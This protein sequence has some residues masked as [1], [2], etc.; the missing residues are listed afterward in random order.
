MYQV[1]SSL[2]VSAASIHMEQNAARWWQVQKLKQGARVWTEFVTAVEGKFGADAYAKALR[3]LRNLKQVDTLDS[4]VHEFEQARYQAA[5][6]NTR[7]DELFFVTQF[8]HGLKLEIQH[9][10]QMHQPTTVDKAA[11]LA[12]LQQEMLEKG[13]HKVARQGYATKQNLAGNKVDGRGQ[14]M[15][16]ELF[17][18]RQV[19]EFRK[20]NGLCYACGEKFEPGHLAKCVRRK[21]VQLN[22]VVTE[23]E[24]MELTDDVLQKLAQE[25]EREDHCCRL[26]FQA[27][28]GTDNEQSMRIRSVVG[29]HTMLM[30]V[31]S[32]SSSNFISQHMVHM[33]GLKVEH[34]QPVKV[35]VASG[36]ALD[37]N[38]MVKNLEWWSHGHFY[39][40]DMRVLP[41]GVFDAIL[42]YEWLMEHSP[43]ECDWIDKVLQFKDA[44]Q[45]VKLYGDGAGNNSSIQ[46]VSVLQVQKWL[47][48]HEVWVM[49]LLE[50][51]KEDNST[52]QHEDIQALLMEFADLFSIPT[53]LP[54]VREFDHH[55]PLLPGAVPVNSK[56]YRYS[57]FHK[58][59]IERQVAALLKAG[60]ITPSASPFASPVLL[61]KKKDGSWRFCVD[62][63]KLNDL[64]IKN[65]FP[66]PLV[67]EI[68]EEL[69][70][71]KYFTSLDL[72]AGY[73]QI[74]M[75][76]T[77]EYKTAF[78]THQ[79]HYQFR[80][81][82]FGLTNALATFKC[83]MNSI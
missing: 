83:A 39:H 37:C 13:R 2:W 16:G 74:R 31:D 46:N 6:H 60:L 53:Q 52:V 7:L 44:G 23:E 78:K 61:V 81:M 19:R 32:G 4:Y 30:L 9:A 42:G 64:T 5:V 26:S 62:Y 55:I 22:A 56:P 82:P 12:Q 41:L 34:C 70:G 36:H 49:V 65:R 8:I 3:K 43:M 59:E 75:G 29:K 17:R 48:G 58:D 66:M 72:T 27:V 24:P 51:V 21:P 40:T 71:T 14:Q 38:T 79:G 54:P 15:G 80:V 50:E 77:E 1:P 35:K 28:S 20:L 57:P 76:I 69:A 33:L 25:D 10:V 73:H 18:E 68:L 47:K 45:W 63:R 11:S 67:E